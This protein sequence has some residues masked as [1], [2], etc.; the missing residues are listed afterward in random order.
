MLHETVFGPED[1]LMQH[2]ERWSGSEWIAKR[3]MGIPLGVI[4]GIDPHPLQAR[5]IALL[6]GLEP[7]DERPVIDLALLRQ[8]STPSGLGGWQRCGPGI[9][10]RRGQTNRT[11]AVS[12][13]KRNQRRGRQRNQGQAQGPPGR[14]PKG[15][16]RDEADHG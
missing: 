9:W 12:L 5:R 11:L 10:Q 2:D 13:P 8:W 6:L 1:R 14:M 7:R 16:L 15:L 3:I 4:G